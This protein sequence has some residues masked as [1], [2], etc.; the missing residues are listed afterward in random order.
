MSEKDYHELALHFDWWILADIVVRDIAL[1]ILVSVLVNYIQVR[2]PDKE[3]GQRIK[4]KVIV[5]FEDGASRQ[6]VYNGPIEHLDKVIE[7]A[8]GIDNGDDAQVHP[9]ISSQC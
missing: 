2:R 1:P 9:D 5:V 7:A 8:K 3:S 6:I 4:L